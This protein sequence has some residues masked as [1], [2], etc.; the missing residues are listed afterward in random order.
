MTLPRRYPRSL[1][2]LLPWVPALLVT[3]VATSVSCSDS[4]S[5][6][7]NLVDITSQAPQI[8]VPDARSFELASHQGKIVVVNFWATWC[9]PCRIE[10][11]A[12]VQLRQTFDPDDVIIVGISVQE[13]GRPEQIQSG[14]ETFIKQN[15]INYPIYFDETQ[16]VTLRFHQIAPFFNTG[17]PATL[18]FD[19]QGRVQ[20][21]HL[22]VPQ[23]NGRLDPLGVLQGDIQQL[24]DAS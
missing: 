17:I 14:L 2:P 6:A 8:P 13:Y 10:I 16:E 1:R 23:S 12:L 20:K 7:P 3:I 18:I 15:K 24:L 11:P 9:G 21:R 4:E 5:P 22:G 19:R